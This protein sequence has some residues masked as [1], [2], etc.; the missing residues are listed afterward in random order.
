MHII[1]L[2]VQDYLVKPF[3]DEQLREKVQKVL[4]IKEKE[5]APTAAPTEAAPPEVATAAEFG[6]AAMR[7]GAG[8]RWSG[9][10]NGSDWKNRHAS[11]MV[12]ERREPGLFQYRR[13]R[14][15]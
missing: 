15:A 10:R 7:L 2:G 6:R 12:D 14:S 3:K 13:I 9:A 4:P 1:A 11:S 5:A 8:M